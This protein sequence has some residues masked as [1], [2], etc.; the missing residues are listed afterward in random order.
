M[1]ER[2]SERAENERAS[3]CARAHARTE[4]QVVH[5]NVVRAQVQAGVG[6]VRRERRRRQLQVLAHCEPHGQQLLVHESVQLAP[7]QPVQQLLG[8][9]HARVGRVVKVLDAPQHAVVAQARV[10][11]GVVD[12]AR[13][14]AVLRVARRERRVGVLEHVAEHQLDGARGAVQVDLVEHHVPARTW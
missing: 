13:E 9:G 3:K 1:S 14:P 11:G 5:A 6:V 10:L 4:L 2:A 7:V 8:G 12:G